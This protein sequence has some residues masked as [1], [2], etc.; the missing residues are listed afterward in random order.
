MTERTCPQC[1]AP[2]KAPPESLKNCVR[3]G[4]AARI[5]VVSNVTSEVVCQKCMTQAELQQTGN[6]IYQAVGDHPICEKCSAATEATW[7]IR[8]NAPPPNRS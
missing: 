4:E 1:G 3:C 6:L 2:L 8:P 5:L 7:R